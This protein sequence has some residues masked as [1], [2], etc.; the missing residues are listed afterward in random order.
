MK[1]RAEV[2]FDPESLGYMSLRTDIKSLH[3]QSGDDEEGR[4][5]VEELETNLTLW[6]GGV[7]RERRAV[8]PHR[9]GV[10]LPSPESP[11]AAAV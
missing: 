4:G 3:K 7:M 11:F 8:S 6:R 9:L 5:N 10:T 2:E 1:C